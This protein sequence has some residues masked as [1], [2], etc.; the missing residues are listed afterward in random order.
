LKQISKDKKKKKK[1]LFSELDH[2]ATCRNV[3]TAIPEG[4]LG[5]LQH[6]TMEEESLTGSWSWKIFQDAVIKR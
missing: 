1:S 3:R 2:K 5:Y 4:M 6:V